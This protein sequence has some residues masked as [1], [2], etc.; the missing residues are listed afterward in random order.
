MFAAV[1]ETT[2]DLMP[3]QLHQLNFVYVLSAEENI[4]Q[5]LQYLS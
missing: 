4:V 3:T 5:A 1:N 2:P